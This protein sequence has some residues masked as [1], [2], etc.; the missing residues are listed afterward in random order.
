MW[1]IGQDFQDWQEGGMGD[2]LIFPYSPSICN[3]QHL[4]V[5]IDVGKFAVVVIVDRAELDDGH[6][7]VEVVYP[8]KFKAGNH[9]ATGIHKPP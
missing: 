8:T 4:T 1:K 9:A 7:L 3:P 2:F 6:P 5:L